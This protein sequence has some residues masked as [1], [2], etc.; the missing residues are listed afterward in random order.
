MN[1]WLLLLKPGQKLIK[2]WLDA[3][4]E[5]NFYL[6]LFKFQGL[7]DNYVLVIFDDCLVI[8]WHLPQQEVFESIFYSYKMLFRLA[9]ETAIG[10]AHDIRQPTVPGPGILQSETGLVSYMHFS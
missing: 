4:E 3:E 6:N 1:H 8:L 9:Q 5:F 2:D 10:S 7:L